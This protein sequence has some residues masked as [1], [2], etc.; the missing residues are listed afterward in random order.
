[1]NLLI[2]GGRVIDP[3]QGLDGVCDVLVCGFIGRQSCGAG[4]V[5]EAYRFSEKR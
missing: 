3:A 5:A 2:K 1:M 4:C